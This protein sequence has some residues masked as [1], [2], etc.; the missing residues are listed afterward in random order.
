MVSFS[1]DAVKQRDSQKMKKKRRIRWLNVIASCVRIA[2]VWIPK[3]EEREETRK[4]SGSWGRRWWWWWC[5]TNL[6]AGPA[7]F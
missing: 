6:D 1:N 7:R 3:S 5:M 4:L 2:L